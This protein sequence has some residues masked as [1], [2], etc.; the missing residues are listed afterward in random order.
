MKTILFS[1]LLGVVVF[2][3]TAQAQDGA[4]KVSAAGL[5]DGSKLPEVNVFNDFGCKGGNRSPALS[6]TEP[7]AK[8]RGLAVTLYDPD[9]P[10]GS[11]WWHWT[12]INLPAN[13][14]GLPEGAGDAA[15]AQ[16][17]KGAV[18]GTYRFR[19]FTIWR[20]LSAA[21]QC[22]ASLYL[23]GF[24]RSTLIICPSMPMLPV[25]CSVSCLTSM[26]LAR[27]PSRFSTG[28]KTVAS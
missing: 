26:S 9:A 11:G 4:F 1:A 18:Q 16:L 15:G 3:S 8:T 17:P 24:G 23:H 10:T 14:R 28:D 5:A 13:L 2:A 27:Q 21:G 25:Q 19:Y 22:A 6:W 20:R 7:P 12:L